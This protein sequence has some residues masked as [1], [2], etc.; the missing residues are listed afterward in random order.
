MLKAAALDTTHNLHGLRHT[1]GTRMAAAGVPMRTLQ[2]WMGHRDI[3][4]TERYA[5]YAPS[6]H[7]AELMERAWRRGS[8]RG[9]N[10]SESA[11]TQDPEKRL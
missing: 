3:S 11:V 8:N 9:S 6:Q 7:E 4:T 5:D 1:F 10:L 2:E